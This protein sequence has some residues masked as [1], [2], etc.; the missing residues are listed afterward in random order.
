MALYQYIKSYPKK[1]IRRQAISAYALITMGCITLLWV[2]W[3]IASFY[4]ITEKLFVK[5][6]SPIS[7][8]SMVL[9]SSTALATD[10]NPQ[11]AP[12][13]VDYA[14]PNVWFPTRPQKK[15]NTH[16]M[17]YTLTIDK[18]KIFNATALIA[19]DDLSKSLVHYGG[20]ALPGTYGVGVI[21]GH[22][23]LPQF[24]D[25]KNYKS[26]FSL[27]P[28]LKIGDPI[29]ITYDGIQYTYIVYDM[30]V[31]EP[32]DLSVLEQRYDDSY[33]TLVTCVPPGT[34]FKRLHVKTKL[35]H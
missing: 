13:Q 25:P 11:N 16:V 2:L 30:E 18:L 1:P 10:I 24:Y 5:T 32:D 4:L 17:A 21:F 6:I 33:M 23:I 3:P 15:V 20:T 35:R 9:A 14:D 27:L 8:K 7:E 19:S 31:T 22:S 34:Y 29:I 26:I 28:T 12:G